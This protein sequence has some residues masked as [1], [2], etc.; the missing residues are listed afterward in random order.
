M[1][2]CVVAATSVVVPL[3]SLLA[4]PTPSETQRRA[5]EAWVAQD[6]PRAAEAYQAL[7]REQPRTAQHHFRLA[8]SLIGLRRHNE[9]RSHL[10][11]AESLGTPASQVAFRLALVHVAGGALDKAFAELRRATTAGL[12]VSPVSIDADPD[13][14]VLKRDVRFAQFLTDL[15]R[16][17]RPCLHDERYKAFDFWLGT[18]EVRPNGQP[19][20]PAARNVI[21]KT[22]DGC[23]LL[24][25]W[26]APASTGQS[27]NVFDRTR[28]KWFQT[29][30]DNSGGLH[31]YSGA[32]RDGN[33]VFEGEMPAPRPGTGR[34]H[35]RLTFFPRPDGSVRQF[36][37]RT[38]DSR[39]TWQVNYDLIYT[40]SP[41][42]NTRPPSP[43]EPTAVRPGDPRINGNF[44]RPYRRDVRQIITDADGRVVN[45]RA[46]WHDEL[47]ET[48]V[49][50]RKVMR[51]IVAMYRFDD[52]LHA[53]D[54]VLFDPSTLEPIYNV[55]W[56]A[57]TIAWRRAFDGPRVTGQ[58]LA[59]AVS[60]SGLGV[61]PGDTSKRLSV[62]LSER[63]F[64][65]FGG[66]DL[67]A[68]AIPLTIGSITRL[69]I[70]DPR[71]DSVGWLDLRVLRREPVEAGRGRFAQAFV[72]EYD[73]LSGPMRLWVSKEAPFVFKSEETIL[74]DGKPSRV[75]TSLMLH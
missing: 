41:S 65:L 2:R 48:E 10:S 20:A 13:V 64:D 33:M 43:T 68:A 9:S 47:V 3:V 8:V 50:G 23:V 69:P 7:I 14:A 39:K 19:S 62:T 49:G 6:W 73:A 30:V 66:M 38:T 45:A 28:G 61:M 24:E 40:H 72:V 63:V 26:S 37:E 70:Y 11:V 44:L 71:I 5:T 36:S 35:T 60:G 15:D 27:F 42:A 16:N 29:W 75:I 31:E 53:A 59:A 12:G 32:L 18:W 57:G 51:R 25:S 55:E 17:V 1:R 67:L 58:R 34:V 54:T 56:V 21:T 4:Q 52:S 46:R 22:H 74:R